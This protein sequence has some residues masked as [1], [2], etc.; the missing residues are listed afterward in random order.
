MLAGFDR[1]DLAQRTRAI[2]LH[3]VAIERRIAQHQPDH[4]VVGAAAL[5]QQL[6]QRVGVG[7][8]GHHRLFGEH[9]EPG[10]EPDT[11]VIEMHVV[12]RTDHQQVELFGLQQGLGRV[13]GGAGIDPRAG[14][15]RHPVRRRIDIAD[16]LRARHLLHGNPRQVRYPGAQPD[17][18]DL[19]VKHLH[20]AGAKLGN[21]R[22][23]EKPPAASSVR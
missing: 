9:L 12:G 5:L 14:Q 11:D 6:E 21:R 3:Q 2:A 22:P 4:H 19:H 20:E 16:Q 8:G 7:L 15:F 10:L 13:V 23:V 18:S 1:G 17:N